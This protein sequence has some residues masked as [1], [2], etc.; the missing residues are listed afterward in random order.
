M[1]RH[2]VLWKIDA[3]YSQTEKEN[4]VQLIYKS[5]TGMKGKIDELKSLAVHINSDEAEDSNF[6][7]ILETT[8]NSMADLNRYIEHPEHQKVSQII[9]EVKKTRAAID[10]LI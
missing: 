6:D 10:Y 7:I 1:I 5:L 8:F 9:K 4:A 3:S 2:I